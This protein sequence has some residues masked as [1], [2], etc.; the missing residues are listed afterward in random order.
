[1]YNEQIE[2]LKKEISTLVNGNLTEEKLTKVRE[3]EAQILDIRLKTK[4]DSVN[5][6]QKRKREL[7]LLAY[8]AEQPEI[9]ITTNDC[10][11]HSV[12][13]KKYPN[14]AALPYC[15]AKFRDGK[16]IELTLNGHTFYMFRT[17]HEYNKPTEYIRPATFEDFLK[18][19][20][21]TE[22]DIYMIE[23]KEML[24]ANEKINNEFKEAVKKFDSQKKELE[25]YF[26]SHIGLF[27][28]QNAGH[29]YEYSANL[30]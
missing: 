25:M 29:I 30:Y 27:K 2:Q 28:Q 19:N 21:I 5:A 13:V 22:R 15:T 18:L 17:K 20:S 24:E 16:Y 6:E 3:I 7:A 12:K 4:L 1:M 10:K 23:F 26:F 14:L 9:D 11:F 8:N